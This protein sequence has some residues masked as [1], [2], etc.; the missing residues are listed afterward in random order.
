MGDLK[1]SFE[2]ELKYKISQKGSAHVSDS[3]L[4][5]KF[6]KFYDLNSTGFI[7]RDGFI[8]TLVK[9]GFQVFSDDVWIWKF[10]QDFYDVFD[11]YANGEE[12][13]NI[14]FLASTIFEDEEL[15]MTSSVMNNKSFMN[16]PKEM[17]GIES[18]IAT[19]KK[20]AK[21]RLLYLGNL[22]KVNSISNF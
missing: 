14:K 13:I 1:T 22:L 11:L 18:V 20:S 15:S 19:I 7:T 10:I 9:I 16:P 5:V 2:S 3:S 12:S 8:K 6:L 21:T 4:F 17:E